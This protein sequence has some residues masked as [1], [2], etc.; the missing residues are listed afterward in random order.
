MTSPKQLRAHAQKELGP[1]SA[2]A[3]GTPEQAA[4]FDA[5]R[6]DGME[7]TDALLHLAFDVSKTNREVLGEFLS[8]FNELLLGPAH[9]QTPATGA[10]PRDPDRTDLMQSVVADLLPSLDGLY[11]S[12]KAEFLSLVHQRLRWKRLDRV[13][14]QAPRPSSAPGTADEMLA[15]PDHLD[16]SA[17]PLAELLYSEAEAL[18]ATAINLLSPEDRRLIRAV[19]DEVPRAQLAEELGVSLEALR[20]RLR[21]ARQSFERKLEGLRGEARP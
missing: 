21:R 16:D 17:S 19:V 4:S 18:I 13:K 11:F 20:Q 15:T 1:E 9:G 3:L 7:P 14:S 8:H 12:S 6:S 5:L 10:A 2:A